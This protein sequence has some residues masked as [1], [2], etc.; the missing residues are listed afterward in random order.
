MRRIRLPAIEGIDLRIKRAKEHFDDLE[1]LITGFLYVDKPYEVVPYDDPKTGERVYQFRIHQPIPPLVSVLV[2][3]I[4]HCLRVS[5]D[6][7]VF[8]LVKPK[9]PKVFRNIA[10][11][12]SKNA[13]DLKGKIKFLQ[14]Q[15]AKHAPVEA[16]RDAMD[17]IRRTEP[18]PRSK[19]GLY[20]IHDLNNR[21]KHRLL[22]ACCSCF[23][24][25]ASG[26]PVFSVEEARAFYRKINAGFALYDGKEFLRLPAQPIGNDEAYKNVKF[27]FDIA[28]GEPRGLKGKAILPTLEG[29]IN[30]IEGIIEP[31]RPVL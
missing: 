7:L 16:A 29:Y 20:C 15:M 17:L 3:D 1:G 24:G 6:H 21:D 31:F 2:G 4:V 25:M 10:F 5:L 11:P 23:S 28:F 22:L 30:L 13:S 8:A 27:S 9:A 18:Y 19:I 26:V 14:A 12:F